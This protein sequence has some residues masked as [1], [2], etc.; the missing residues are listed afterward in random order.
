MKV[1]AKSA[2]LQLISCFSCSIVLWVRLDSIGA[3]EFRGG[4]LTGPLFEMADIA[5]FIFLVAL[6]LTFLNPR[7]GG[8]LAIASCLLILPF[9]FYF[10][11]PALF[12]RLFPGEYSVPLQTNFIWDSW[13][14]AG[15]AIAAFTV[16]VCISTL[17]RRTE[18]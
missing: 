16:M 11:A 12:R 15:I 8:V 10:V 18:A 3:S 6:L 4:S 1:P 17:R 7:F 9:Y 14:I 5:G 13:A 2:W